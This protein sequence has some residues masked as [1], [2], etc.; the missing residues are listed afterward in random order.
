MYYYYHIFLFHVGILIIY[1]YSKTHML[2]SLYLAKVN[3]GNTLIFSQREV[4]ISLW[5]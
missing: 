5:F 3:M 1:E 2:L 4:L